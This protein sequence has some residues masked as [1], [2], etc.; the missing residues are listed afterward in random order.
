MACFAYFFI[1]YISVGMKLSLSGYEMN[2]S[3]ASLPYLPYLKQKVHSKSCHLG[4]WN[5]FRT[6]SYSYLACAAHTLEFA[7]AHFAFCVQRSLFCALVFWAS[8]LLASVYLC[9]GVAQMFFRLFVL[10]LLIFLYVCAMLACLPLCFC[11]PHLLLLACSCFIILRMQHARLLAHYA[12][13]IW[14]RRAA[15]RRDFPSTTGPR[16]RWEITRI[17]PPLTLPLIDPSIEV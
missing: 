6:F 4:T 2:I 16:G 8:R 11:A 5:P 15:S 13:Q 14:Q 3:F 12:M 17:S 9:L 7:Y 10:C 1:T